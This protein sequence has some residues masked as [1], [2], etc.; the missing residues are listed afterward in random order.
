VESKTWHKCTYLQN[1]NKLTNIDNRLVVAKGE[2]GVSGMHWELGVSRC[3]LL[4][5]FY[6]IYLFIYFFVFL[7]ISWA[8]PAAYGVPRLG[9]ESEMQ[10]PAYARATA[11]RDPSCVCNLHHSSRQHR[12]LN[13]LSKARDQT[14]NLM[15][16]SRIC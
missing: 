11:M 4:H 9:V 7:A 12:I 1:R 15:V 6:F 2:G 14:C 5:L 13:P 16:P 3:K 8:A 10:P